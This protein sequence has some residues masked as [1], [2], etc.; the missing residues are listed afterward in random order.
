MNEVQILK[1]KRK[2]LKP[3]KC[4]VNPRFSSRNVLTNSPWDFVDLWLKKECQSDAL[5]YWTQSRQFHQASIGLPTQSAPLL[6]YYSF[7]NAVK[8]MLTSKGINFNQYHGLTGFNKRGENTKISLSNEG[9]KIKG[10]GILPALSAYLGETESVKIHSLKD[11][12][13]NL[14]YIHRTYCLSHPSQTE[15][16]IPIKKAEFVMDK[17]TKE[18]YFRAVLSNDYANRHVI[19]RLP[20]NFIRDVARMDQFAVRSQSSISFSKPERPTEVDLENLRVFHKEMRHDL[21]YINGAET[22]WYIKSRPANSSGINRFPTTITL[23]V[24][25]RLSEIS[26]YNPLELDVFLSGEKNWLISEFI[27]QSPMQFLDEIASEITGFQFMTP[28][29][30]TAT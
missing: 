17:T 7:M 16:Y 29:V 19:N 27:Q 18:A 24:M 9:V 15:M 4:I 26:R 13:F 3:H 22:L 8:A 1:W 2:T 10:N 25:H 6:H 14:P 11:L 23:A 21:Q 20:A 5:F 12:L 30:R 28:N